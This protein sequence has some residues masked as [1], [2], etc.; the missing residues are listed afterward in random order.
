MYRLLTLLLYSQLDYI[1]AYCY[2]QKVSLRSTVASTAGHLTKAIDIFT[3]VLEYLKDHL[4]EHI[5]QAV[6]EFVDF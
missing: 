4:M 6:A 2:L 1:E 3:M 5:G